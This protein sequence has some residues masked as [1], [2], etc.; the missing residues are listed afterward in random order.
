MRHLRWIVLLIVI[1]SGAGA[2]FA[3][4]DRPSPILSILA[5]TPD[6]PEA[7]EFFSYL[8]LEAVARGAY[9]LD[10]FIQALL[11]V[12]SGP[13]LSN[14]VHQAET[15]QELI[16]VSVFEMLQGAQWGAP[17]ATVTILQGEFDPAAIEAAYAA[18]D[19]TT[20]QAA[21]LTVYCGPAGCD[22]GSRM[23]PRDR[24][25]GDPFGGNLGRQQP[26]LLLPLADEGYQLLSSASFEVVTNSAEAAT[27]E[28]PSL[29]D[30]P[31]WQ[32]AVR[33]VTAGG[34]L[35]QAYFTTAEMVTPEADPV[36]PLSPYE[37]L[38]LAETGTDDGEISSATLVYPA[39]AEAEAAAASLEVR[40]EAY[41]SLVFRAPLSDRL[42]E[43]EQTYAVTA[44]EDADTGLGIMQVVFRGQPN[45]LS[46]YRELIRGL[47]SRDLGWL[48]V[49]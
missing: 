33:A 6:V 13:D 26:V 14:F 4:D 9:D 17:P 28:A 5:S 40:I 42:R 10:T 46:F 44:F 1:L 34:E 3:Q 2:S 37:L 48:G 22:A 49:S 15:Q 20:D 41:Q 29:A 31:A 36:A 30:D 47:L 11:G 38:V 25:P 12:S 16:G 8:D 18:R 27:G 43:R 21:G 24:E 19:Y 32:A 35:R 45:E 23:S 7:R 39:L